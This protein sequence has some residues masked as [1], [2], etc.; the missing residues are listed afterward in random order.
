MQDSEM[1]SVKL[2]KSN[3]SMV[4]QEERAK[5]TS[6]SMNMTKFH[7]GLS[8]CQR[9]HSGQLSLP[10]PP[11][12]VEVWFHVIDTAKSLHMHDILM[13]QGRQ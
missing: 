7:M 3:E 2:S 4:R 11:V 10:A 8:K 6:V 1:V 9:A 13:I 12:V 5:R